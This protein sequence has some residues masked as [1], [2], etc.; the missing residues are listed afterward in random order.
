MTAIVADEVKRAMLDAGLA[1]L[2]L[3][4]S[5]GDSQADILITQSNDTSIATC[6]M[7]AP[8]CFGAAATAST[9]TKAAANAISNSGTP[10]VNVD[11]GKLKLRNRSNTVLITFSVSESGGGGDIIVT[12]NTVPSNATS[13]S[14]SGLEITITL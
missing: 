4:T 14:I 9:I 6:N 12:D 7:S 5:G 8:P 2:D 1:R 11:I 13:I 10:A 3:P